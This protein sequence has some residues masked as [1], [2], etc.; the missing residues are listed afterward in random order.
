MN[1]VDKGISEGIPAEDERIY[2]IMIVDDERSVRR[3]LERTFKRNRLFKSELSL[4]HN[5]A[6]ALNELERKRI[7]LVISDFKMPGMNGIDLLENVKERFPETVR[8]LITGFS[9]INVAREAADRAEVHAY[10]EKPWDNVEMPRVI[11]E[12]LTLKMK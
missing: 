2:N 12:A 9:D 6:S 3:A 4:H 7:D 1:M 10:L 11:H 8:V 5:A